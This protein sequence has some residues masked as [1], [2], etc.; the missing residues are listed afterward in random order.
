MTIIEEQTDYTLPLDEE[1]AQKLMLGKYSGLLLGR[2]AFGILPNCYAILPTKINNAFVL[3]FFI[4]IEAYSIVY[5][6]DVGC[7]TR[8]CTFH[9]DFNLIP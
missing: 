4:S 7:I 9:G 8:L 5:P 3:L 6:V 1:D 2:R